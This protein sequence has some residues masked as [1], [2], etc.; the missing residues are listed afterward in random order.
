[1]QRRTHYVLVIMYSCVVCMELLVAF[2]GLYIAN[3]FD[4]RYM[5]D[6]VIG[7]CLCIMAMSIPLFSKTRKTS[8]AILLSLSTCFVSLLLFLLIML[9]FDKKL[10][11]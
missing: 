8:D 9:P 3:R 5:G 6:V 11:T 7:V 10:G 2:G 4:V 1:M